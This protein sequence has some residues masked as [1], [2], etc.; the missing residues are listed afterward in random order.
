MSNLLNINERYIAF[1]D[2][3]TDPESDALDDITIADTLE[4]LDDEFEDKA[5]NIALLTKQIDGNIN[6]LKKYKDDIDKK[7]KRHENTKKSIKDWLYFNAKQVGKTKFKTNRFSY[8]SQKHVSVVIDKVDDLPDTFVKT[9]KSANKTMISKSLKA[10]TEIKGAH[11]V[12]KESMV[13][14]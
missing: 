2:R 6:M 1:L 10:G 7:I 9:E 14:R 8:Y 5:D 12:E 13:I 3:A 11:L 4:A